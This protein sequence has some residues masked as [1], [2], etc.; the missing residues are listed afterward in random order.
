MFVYIIVVKNDLQQLT[1]PLKRVAA[2]ST[3]AWASQHSAG[4]SSCRYITRLARCAQHLCESN[5]Q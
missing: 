1:T 3:E 5:P 2:M 4:T